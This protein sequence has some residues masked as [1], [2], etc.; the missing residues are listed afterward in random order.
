MDQFIIGVDLG[1]TQVRAARFTPALDL[2]DRWVE[3][4]RAHEGRDRVLA[5]MLDVIARVMPDD[6]ASVLGIGV[7]APGPINPRTGIIVAP[8]NLPGWHNVPLRSIVEERFKCQTY[9]G[10]DANVAALA[11]TTHGAA[12]GYKH[13][14]YVTVSTG[15]GSGIIDEGRLVIGAQGLGAEAGHMI[16][17]VGDRVSTLEKEAAGPAI[18]RK[19]IAR[20]QSGARSIIAER[21][22]DLRE[23][24]AKVVG[25]AAADGDALAIELI[26]EAG[27]LVG[28]GLVTM[29]HLFNPQVIVVGGGVTKT[30]DL[31]FEPMRAAV[32][33]YVLD[34][35]YC[36]HVPI[37]PAALGDN[38]ALIGA[39]ALVT[40]RGGSY[41]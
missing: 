32:R 24:T 21:V 23:I 12:Q 36:E 25:Q 10:N 6:P 3:P 16:M 20:L 39:A 37:I 27:R 11:E 22:S 2:L 35:A 1:G 14:I 18:A 4:T 34:Q 29:M 7:S 13:V 26:A 30:G 15:I 8:P 17:L 28:L 19:A 33:E 5:R 40:T 9:L 31:L 41:L 38:V